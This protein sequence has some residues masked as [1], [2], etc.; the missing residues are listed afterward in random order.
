M[1]LR[2]IVFGLVIGAYFLNTQA[3]T[4]ARYLNE[5]FSKDVFELPPNFKG[6]NWKDVRAGLIR[7]RADKDQ[8]ESVAEFKKRVNLLLD[9]K[10]YG[11]V[12]GNGLLAFV[13]PTEKNY[14]AEKKRLSVYLS[15]WYAF[16]S[17]GGILIE[18]ISNSSGSYVGQNSFGVT[19]TVEK[20]EEEVAI[21]FAPNI[22]PK[23]SGKKYVPLSAQDAR[24]IA[25]KPLDLV[26]I[27]RITSPYLSSQKT[28]RSPT[29]DSPK[30]VTSNKSIFGF[31]FE[32]I[33]LVD[34]LTGKII[35]K[36]LKI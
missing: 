35:S 28:Y 1:R 36:K 3:Q 17:K 18:R 8:F 9:T 20:I 14:D 25:Y 33:W 32:E 30:E 23:S 19:Q 22:D 2:H 27:G 16:D 21:L 12:K 4:S 7:I 29:L 34:R 24:E 6:N 10:L 26:Y 11:S 31:K 13:V 15:T 5:N